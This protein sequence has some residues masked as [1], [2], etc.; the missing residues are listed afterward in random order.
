MKEP[1]DDA[2]EQAL[3]SAE[4]NVEDRRYNR[5]LPAG[6]VILTNQLIIDI[7]ENTKSIN[8][9]NDTMDLNVLVAI[10]YNRGSHFNC[11]LGAS[12]IQYHLTHYD[13]EEN[14]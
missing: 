6:Q 13:D 4:S 9:L 14:T 7:R 5:N 10:V 2:I 12:R 11:S 3:E 1:S 8:K